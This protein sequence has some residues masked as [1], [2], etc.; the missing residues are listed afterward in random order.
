MGRP[1]SVT[2]CIVWLVPVAD[3]L[4]ADIAEW[5]AFNEVY[6]EYFKASLPARSAL[7]A[8]GLAFGA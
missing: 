6:R 3:V 1:L 2:V 5:P 8:S 4:T 7:A